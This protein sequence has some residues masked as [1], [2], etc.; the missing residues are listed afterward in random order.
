MESNWL[1]V[2][3]DDGNPKEF[4]KLTLETC[5]SIADNTS[6]NYYVATTSDDISTQPAPLWYPITPVNR[7]PSSMEILHPQIFEIGSVAN[8][9]INDKAKI[10]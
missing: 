3:N 10:L 2:V 1:Y 6:I 9:I 5:E 8:Q 4:E 7:D